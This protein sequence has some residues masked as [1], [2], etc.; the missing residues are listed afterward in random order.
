MVLGRPD[1]SSSWASPRRRATRPSKSPSPTRNGSQSQ[2]DGERGRG[3]GEA[4]GQHER[5]DEDEHE[6]APEMV[7][8]DPLSQ[9]GTC[10]S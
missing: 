10:C 3:R 8:M 5:K 6:R 1:S 2:Q 9:V 7:A 4:D